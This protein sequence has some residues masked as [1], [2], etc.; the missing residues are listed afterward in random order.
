M[1]YGFDLQVNYVESRKKSD[2]RE[3][4]TLGAWDMLNNSDKATYS[5]ASPSELYKDGKTIISEERGVHNW[6]MIGL[7][8]SDLVRA[9]AHLDLWFPMHEEKRWFQDH[10][11]QWS[12]PSA[13]EF[14]QRG[15]S[16][17]VLIEA[18]VYARPETV[19]DDSYG[20]YRWGKGKDGHNVEL[21]LFQS[22]ALHL[23]RYFGPVKDDN[24]IEYGIYKRQELL[25]IERELF[26]IPPI[27]SPNRRADSRFGWR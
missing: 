15:S 17:S 8:F 21:D 10:Y 7:D 1:K 5:A 9:M 23:G 12:P 24:S 25:K 6:S 14:T 27:L 18:E 26:R 2:M 20:F 3:F 4:F 16:H 19:S 11:A 22:V 13:F